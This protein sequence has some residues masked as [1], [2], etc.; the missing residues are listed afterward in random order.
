MIR[1]KI[2]IG[3]IPAILWGPSAQR[4]CLYIHGQGGNK[5]EA[6]SIAGLICKYGYQ[7]LSVDL[8]EHGERKGERNCFDPWHVKPELNIV[9]A[10]AKAHWTQITLFAVSIGAWFSMLSFEKEPLKNCLF[11]SPVPDM[12]LLIAKMMSQA[13]VS[14]ARLSRELTIQTDFGQT[15]S[16]VYWQYV[17]AHPIERWPVPTK[18]LYGENDELIEYETVKQ[19]AG[20]YGCE[21]MVMENGGHWFHTPQQLAFLCR[22]LADA[23]STMDTP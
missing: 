10:Y 12:K 19:F 18:I 21:L 6:E 1:A 14:E 13:G 17:L 8:P 9:M 2:K 4:L 23:L 3:H 11:V 20:K 15:L 16:W 22:W 5:E 7:M